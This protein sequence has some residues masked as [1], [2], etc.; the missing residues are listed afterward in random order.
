MTANCSWSPLSGLKQ[1]LV[2]DRLRIYRGHGLQGL[3][4]RVANDRSG[5]SCD[6]KLWLSYTRSW[7]S[8]GH[9]IAFTLAQFQNITLCNLMSNAKNDPP[10][11]PAISNFRAQELIAEAVLVCNF[12]PWLEI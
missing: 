11:V 9:D 1:L 6:I 5:S 10:I 3:V 8:N 2:L 4:G 12:Q 7:W